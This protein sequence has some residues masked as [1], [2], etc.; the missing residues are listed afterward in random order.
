MVPLDGEIPM[1]AASRA[2][3]TFTLLL[4]CGVLPP[5]PAQA[6]VTGVTILS[7]TTL[8]GSFGSTGTYERLI[9]RV[10]FALD[11]EDPANA[12]IVDLAFAARGADGKVH[13]SSDLYVLQPSDPARGNGVLLFELPN[14]GVFGV[15][16]GLFN[17]GAAMVDVAAQPNVGD[18]LLMRDGYTL[19]WLGWEFD[20]PMPRL[21][22]DPPP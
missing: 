11:P 13:F 18:R 1:S 17:R 7:R 16:L 4:L 6:E 21:R 20:V 9:G 8:E 12:S 5:S 2:A 19:V 14:R 22:L 15:V 10:E 3:V